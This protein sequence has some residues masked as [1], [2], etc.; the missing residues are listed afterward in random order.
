MATDA[1]M[2]VVVSPEGTV[3]EGTATVTSGHEAEFRARR[4]AE[5]EFVS[6]MYGHLF[7]KGL[8]RLTHSVWEVARE[9]GFQCVVTPVTIEHKTGK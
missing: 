1:Y 3:W 6:Q 8:S 9:N 2:A 4:Q 7:K 5:M